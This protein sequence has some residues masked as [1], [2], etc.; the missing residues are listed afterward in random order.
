MPFHS[1][2]DNIRWYPEV[3]DEATRDEEY[4]EDDISAFDD[5]Y[6]V[7][8]FTDETTDHVN[9]NLYLPPDASPNPRYDTEFQVLGGLIIN[10]YDLVETLAG[11]VDL[12]QPS[13]IER[14]SPARA[15][16]ATRLRNEALRLTNIFGVWS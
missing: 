1:S 14:M 12:I 5:V 4:H 8:L 15:E 11:F 7:E 9:L 6:G 2:L 13:N 16:R 10:G 3:D